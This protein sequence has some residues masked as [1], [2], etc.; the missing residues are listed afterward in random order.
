MRTWNLITAI[1]NAGWNWTGGGRIK[2]TKEHAY[3]I[4]PKDKTATVE[5]LKESIAAKKIKGL[6]YRLAV[7]S[8]E[9]APEIKRVVLIRKSFA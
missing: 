5:R 3:F 7:S 1:N 4:Y 6:S 9:Y 8:P 2:A